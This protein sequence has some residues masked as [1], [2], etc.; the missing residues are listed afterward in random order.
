[1]AMAV[2]L[3]KRRF[4]VEEYHR[5]AEAGILSEDDRVELIRGEVVEM[6]P[7]GRRH[8]GVVDRLNHLLTSRLG[9]RAIV[10]VQG[11]LPLPPDSEP[12]PDVQVLRPCPDFY[13]DTPLGP[14]DVLLLIEVADTTLATDRGVKMP[15]YAEA[16]IREVWLVD[17]ESGHVVVH[18]EPGP[19]GYREIRTAGRGQSLQP[20]ALPDLALTVD[21]ILG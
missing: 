6:A 19:A 10:R 5:M 8:A 7:I 16:G 15:L 13:V 14:G 9:G 11:P 20:V 12:E 17:L 1:M 2:T 3:T 4:T 21:E 18:L